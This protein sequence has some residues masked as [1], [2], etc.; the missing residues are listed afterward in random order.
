MRI[1]NKVVPIYANSEAGDRRHVRQLDVCISVR[2]LTRHVSSIS[3]HLGNIPDDPSRPWFAAAP[4]GENKLGTMVKDMFAEVGVVNRTNHNLRATG[5]TDLYA[6][7]V[8]QKLIQQ[9]TGHRSL[10]AL[11]IYERTTGE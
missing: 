1:E 3:R 6:A 11:R 4:V 9:C 5:A 2:F 10:K 8:P 7:A